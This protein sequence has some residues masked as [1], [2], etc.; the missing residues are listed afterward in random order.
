[1]KRKFLA[2]TIFIIVAVAVFFGIQFITKTGAFKVYGTLNISDN[3]PADV[4]AALSSVT[5]NET[6]IEHDIKV[7]VDYS[8]E[9]PQYLEC[10]IQLGC[11][12]NLLYDVLVPIT[13]FYDP[14]NSIS[15][16][17][18]SKKAPE[19]IESYLALLGTYEISDKNEADPDEA[20]RDA[21]LSADGFS[22]NFI[23]I[24]NL[25]KDQK[26]LAINYYEDHDEYY[27]DTLNSGAIFVYVSIHILAQDDKAFNLN[28]DPERIL[29]EGEQK[30]I[31]L[32]KPVLK[33][34]PTTDT[35]LSFAQTGVT[36]LSRGMLT[37]LNQVGGNAEYFAENIKDFLSSKDLTHISNES[38]FTDYAT[39][40]NICADPRMIGA[41]TAIGTDIVELTGNHNL[42]CG[43]EAVIN[44]IDQYQELGMMIV[45]GG[46]SAEEAATPLTIN[47]KG[48]GITFLAYN[49]STGGATYDSTPGANQYYEED[50]AENIAAAKERGDIVIVD[51]Q[52]YECSM[53]VSTTEDET[54]DYANSSAGDQ[55]GFFR[56][57]ID[58]GADIVIGTSAHQAQTYELY[59]NGAIYYGL[60]NLFFDQIW[61]PGTTRSLVLTHYFW[62]GKLLNTRITPTVYDNNMQVRLMDEETT[63]WFIERLNQARP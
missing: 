59:G 43:D 62:N 9:Y 31:N 19:I 49:Q 61:W 45:G 63:E 4:K 60:G 7:N 20:N 12:V 28:Y 57:L 3:V 24:L 13:D 35:V 53:Y 26:L 37:K 50:A 34:F 47:Q 36:A 11:Q 18:V 14:K 32:I 30:I 23:S 1:M 2:I 48:T 33:D 38:S 29:D 6:K 17:S 15:F 40:Q 55:I 8:F 10:N 22:D 51:I 25:A 56:H 44:T 41:I 54:C 21:I 39:A 27:L 5:A 58:L 42:D 46:K 52:Y 16:D